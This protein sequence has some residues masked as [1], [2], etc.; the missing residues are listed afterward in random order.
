M[1]G[2][3]GAALGAAAPPSVR[4]R[5]LVPVGALVPGGVPGAEDVAF[6]GFVASGAGQKIIREYGRKAIGEALYD[7]AAYARQYDD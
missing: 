4:Y 3:S 7:D 2:R 6:I 5:G 1:L